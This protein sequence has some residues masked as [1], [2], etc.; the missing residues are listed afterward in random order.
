V[1]ALDEDEGDGEEGAIEMG[2]LD[3]EGGRS[4]NAASGG[5]TQGQAIALSTT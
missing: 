4:N 3:I 2:E 5:G 1:S